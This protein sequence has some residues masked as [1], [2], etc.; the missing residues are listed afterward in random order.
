LVPEYLTA[1]RKSMGAEA[2]AAFEKNCREMYDQIARIA[3][4]PSWVRFYHFSGPHADVSEGA[5]RMQPVGTRCR[6]E[7]SDPVCGS[8]WNPHPGGC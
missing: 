2:A 6:I 1:V 7:E 3:I 5:R 4:V 8:A